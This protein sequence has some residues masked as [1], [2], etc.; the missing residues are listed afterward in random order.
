MANWIVSDILQ[1]LKPF[2]FLDF[3]ELF[4]IV[5]FL[6]FKLCTNAKLDCLK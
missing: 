2:N 1:Y 3:I 5:L 4:E 6:R